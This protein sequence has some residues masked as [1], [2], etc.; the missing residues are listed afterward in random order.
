MRPAIPLR[1]GFLALVLLTL[2]GGCF[3][4]EIDKAGEW[5][6]SK[7]EAEAASATAT[8][9]ESAKPKTNWW[10]SATSLGSEAPK[11]DIVHCSVGN[12]SQFMGRED[13]L[14]RGGSIE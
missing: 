8:P 4:D 2:A 11:A 5:Q 3:L 1:N 7:P 6:K 14:A 13:C 12:S 10:A 9:Q